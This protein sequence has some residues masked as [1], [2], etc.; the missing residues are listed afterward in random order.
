M[1]RPRVMVQASAGHTRAPAAMAARENVGASGLATNRITEGPS[2]ATATRATAASATPMLIRFRFEDR[3]RS[4][5]AAQTAA[6]IAALPMVRNARSA[7]S[8]ANGVQR[9]DIATHMAMAMA[10]RPMGETSA[11]R[12]LR[13]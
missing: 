6:A 11:S 9:M 12:H 1:S 2:N 8:R 7:A 5:K 4:G 3:I 13:T 10:T